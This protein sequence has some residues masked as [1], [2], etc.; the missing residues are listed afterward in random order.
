MQERNLALSSEGIKMT[1]ASE[2]PHFVDILGTGVVIY[3]LK[4]INCHIS[5]SVRM[6][7]CFM[8]VSQEGQTRIGSN[9]SSPKADIGLC[10]HCSLIYRLVALIIWPQA[11]Q[12][13]KDDT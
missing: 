2:H 8:F 5:T 1:V 7:E 9:S 4:V 10:K 3:H 11:L 13:P 12:E 6:L